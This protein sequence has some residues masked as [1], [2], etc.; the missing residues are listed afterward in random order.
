VIGQV[1]TGL[2]IW[3]HLRS[4]EYLVTRPDVDGERIG[5]VGLSMGEEHAMYV[6]ALDDRVQASVLSCCMRQL[7]PEIK[8]KVHCICSYVPGLF[9]VADWPDICALIA[10]RPVLVEQGI[11]DYVPMDLVRLGEAKM[12]RA[13]ELAGVPERI[14]TDYFEGG[15]QFSGRK[16]FAWM[17]R[18]LKGRHN[19]G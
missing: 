7:R 16:A 17:D 9:A 8:D 5:V 18:W 6:A 1:L 11:H 13:Y 2:R 10:P 12:R 4:L 14:D 15:H 19:G 3:D